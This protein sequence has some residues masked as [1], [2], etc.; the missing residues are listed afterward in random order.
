MVFCL[1]VYEKKNAVRAFNGCAEGSNLDEFRF[2]AVQGKTKKV[3]RPVNI[4]W[5]LLYMA[6][7]TLRNSRSFDTVHEEKTSPAAGR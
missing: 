5:S 3:K 7:L 4:V 2:S 6:G 1:I